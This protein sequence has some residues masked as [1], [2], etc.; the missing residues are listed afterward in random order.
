MSK[1]GKVAL[2]GTVSALAVTILMLTGI[3]SIAT[4]ALPA[5]AGMLSV[6]LVI[7]GGVRLGFAMFFVCSALSVLIVPDKEAVLYFIGF[8]GY[9]PIIKNIAERMKNKALSYIIKFLVFNAAMIACFFVSIV[10]LSIPKESFMIA[11]YYVP[12]I[13]LIVGNPIFLL[14]DRCLSMMIAM[15][16]VKWRKH[17]F[18]NFR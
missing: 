16:V 18:K 4:F 1:A 15:Y 13:F 11:G 2:C 9:Y 17:I 12:W 7:E 8:F 6:I 3:V 10:V 5:I 14:Y